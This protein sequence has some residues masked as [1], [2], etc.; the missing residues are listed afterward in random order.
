MRQCVRVCGFLFGREREREKE[1][2]ANN[3][4]R[5]ISTSFCG[6][7]RQGNERRI[8]IE[9]EYE[10]ND[11]QPQAE[12]KQPEEHMDIHSCT[13]TYYLFARIV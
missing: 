8:C 11:D 12:A 4:P 2:R 1:Q 9:F 13:F 6:K 7:A 10:F 3:H 5:E